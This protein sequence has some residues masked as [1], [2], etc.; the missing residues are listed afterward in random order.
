MNGFC[1]SFGWETYENNEIRVA[2]ALACPEEHN[3]YNQHWRFSLHLFQ[4]LEPEIQQA[5][6]KRIPNVDDRSANYLAGDSTIISDIPRLSKA[7]AAGN[8]VLN[9][10][11]TEANEVILLQET[12]SIAEALSRM[13]SVERVNVWYNCKAVGTLTTPHM[14]LKA[15]HLS[16]YSLEQHSSI[17]EILA[18]WAQCPNLEEITGGCEK[19]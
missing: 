10:D 8:A 1:S 17:D 15:I 4:D 16:C 9:G 19:G 18:L 3:H 13:P 6:F 12:P 2:M 11:T 7:I 5:L 14:S